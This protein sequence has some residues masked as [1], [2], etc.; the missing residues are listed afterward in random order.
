MPQTSDAA[1]PRREVQALR[2][3]GLG[4]E[5]DPTPPTAAPDPGPPPAS[6]SPD[7]LSWRWSEE[8]VAST[9]IEPEW[10]WEGYLAKGSKT[11]L[12][13]LSKV[14]KTTLL[15]A[16]M[17]AIGAGAPLFTRATTQG[18]IIL[19]SEEG[20]TSLGPKL[21]ALPD[22]TVRVVNRDSC[23]PKPTWPA[24]V[25]AATAEGVAIGAKTLI[26]D[27]LAFWASFEGDAE[28]NAGAAQAAVDVLDEACRA[29]LAVLVIH[30]QT[31]AAG[32]GHGTGLRGSG[33][34]A[35]AFDVIVEYE[36]LGEDAPPNQRRLVALSRLRGTPDVL[37]VDYHRE[38]S[39]W[40][41]IGE[42]EDRSASTRF[43][44]RERLLSVLA[45]SS[46]FTEGELADEL[47][48]DKRKVA[49]PLRELRQE[50]LIERTGEGKKGDPFVYFPGAS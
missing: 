44:A 38:D 45:G 21:A 46:G 7:G 27:S 1:S 8:V 48:L 28:N 37:V 18:V 5:D 30:H 9:P 47:G 43:G 40:Q 50:G 41:V 17:A 49:G 23:W 16:L 12:A 35:G 14:G 25:E 13:G 22:R 3:R 32:R 19:A 36:R 20:D 33:A 42:A 11:I 29:G 4:S 34:I 24:L 2:A 6:E 31:K 39:S 26:V 10:V 15:E